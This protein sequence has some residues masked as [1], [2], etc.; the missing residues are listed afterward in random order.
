VT[1]YPTLAE[2]V[3]GTEAAVLAKA[4]RVEL[5]DSALAWAALVM[6]VDLDGGA[7]EPDPPEVDDA[8]SAML[9]IAAHEVDEAGSRSGSASTF[10]SRDPSPNL[11]PVETDSGALGGRNDTRWNARKLRRT[12]AS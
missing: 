3:T 9:A 5:A 7:R 12:P 8:G 4:A 1:R 6:V 11:S 2:Q 10:T